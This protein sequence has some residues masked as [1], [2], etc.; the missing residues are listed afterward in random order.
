[1]RLQS[2]EYI[3]EKLSELIPIKYN[4]FQWWRN[5]K[6][7]DP[8]HP[9]TSTLSKVRNGE[10]EH[11]P[12]YWMAQEALVQAEEKTQDVK[13]SEKRLEI[14]SLYMEKHRRLQEDYEKDEKKRIEA[15]QKNLIKRTKI[16]YLELEALMETFDGTVEELVLHV[17]SLYLPTIQPPPKFN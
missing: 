9:Y 6:T 5:Y 14:L 8:L 3:R 10:F 4:K 17:E 12:Y 16:T 13:D 1:M 2:K 7:N 11:S 15:L